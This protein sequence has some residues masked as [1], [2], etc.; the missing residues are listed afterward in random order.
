MIYYRLVDIRFANHFYIFHI[1]EK[2]SKEDEK[3]R[4]TLHFFFAQFVHYTLSPFIAFRQRR[5]VSSLSQSARLKR[6]KRKIT[7]R[8]YKCLVIAAAKKGIFGTPQRFGSDLGTSYW[9]ARISLWSRLTLRSWFNTSGLQN[10][11][12]SNFGNFVRALLSLA[13]V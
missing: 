6:G 9:P 3:G 7:S 10:R 4:Y 8:K 1:F 11:S 12:V 5:G 2:V 13:S